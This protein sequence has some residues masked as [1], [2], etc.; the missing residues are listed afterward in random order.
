MSVG[1]QVAEL[2]ERLLTFRSAGS[3][4]FVF[5]STFVSRE[6]PTV[7]KYQADAVRSVVRDVVGSLRMVGDQLRDARELAQAAEGGTAARELLSQAREFVP[8]LRRAD[9]ATATVAGMGPEAVHDLADALEQR[10]R[11]DPGL[12]GDQQ[13][14]LELLARAQPALGP[15]FQVRED[16]DGDRDGGG[17]PGPVITAITPASAPPGR[18]VTIS[19]D[20]F[21]G[22]GPRSGVQFGAREATVVEWTSVSVRAVVPTMSPQPVEVVVRRSIDEGSPPFLF[23]VL[24]P[25]PPPGG[26]GSDT[27]PDTGSDDQ[28]DPPTTVAGLLRS[29][30]GYLFDDRTRITPTGFALGEHVFSLSLAPAEEVVLEQRTYTKRNTTLEEELTEERQVDTEEASSYSTE[31]SEALARENRS[32]TSLDHKHQHTLGAKFKIEEIDFNASASTSFAASLATAN[33]LTQSASS[34]RSHTESTRVA[35][36]MR[37]A[38]RIDFQLSTETGF[39]TNARRTVRNPNRGTGLSLQYFKMLSALELRHERTAVRLCWAP[40]VKDPGAGVRRRAEEAA[41][42][43]RARFPLDEGIPPKPELVVSQAERRVFTSLSINLNDRFGWPWKDMSTD[44]DVEVPVDD[45]FEWDGSPPVVR[46]TFTGNRPSGALVMGVP[47][48]SARSYFVPVHVGIDWTL[49]GSRGSA[50]VQVS[51]SAVNTNSTAAAAAMRQFREDTARWVADVAR[52]RR[53]ALEAGNVAAASATERILNDADPLTELLTNVVRSHFPPALRDDFAEIDLWHR[54]FDLDGSCYSL[55][56]SPWS[57]ADPPVPLRASDSFVN[58]S[59]ARLYLPVRPGSERAALRLVLGGTT[60]ALPDDQEAVVN[61][62]IEELEGFRTEHYG[63]PTGGP[64]AGDDSRAQERFDTLLTWTD[65]LPTDGTH[66]EAVLSSSWALDEASSQAQL[67]EAA[68]RQA[69]IGAR[70]ADRGLVEKATSLVDSVETRVIVGPDASDTAASMVT[71]G[72][73]SRPPSP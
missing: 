52:L 55:Y 32:N 16:G 65:Y 37:A 12:A 54:V 35:S 70:N 72:V 71:I 41:A 29:S 3:Q 60:G 40:F 49:T 10:L 48:R 33:A 15:T 14:L 27:G 42:L 46:L 34:K 20:R 63:S 24:A 21:A 6:L 28:A 8:L 67:D 2:P 58:A 51:L 45:G 64:V 73:D 39:E 11:E 69:D 62:L 7:A 22:R 23:T 36:K 13:G 9:P 38:H 19:G 25:E 1:R 47:A 18:V 50:S 68:M 31:L 44:V 17:V 4:R 5:W 30:L 56:A 59:W 66:V 43:E 61:E 57:G 26:G 53:A